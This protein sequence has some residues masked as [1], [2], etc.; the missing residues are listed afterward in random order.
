M[1]AAVASLPQTPGY[2]P[3]RPDPPVQ[4]E[5]EWDADDAFDQAIANFDEKQ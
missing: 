5:M 2:G 1:A 3:A 4:D